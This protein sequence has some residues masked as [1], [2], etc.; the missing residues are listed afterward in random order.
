PSTPSAISELQDAFGS[1]LLARKDATGVNPKTVY[2][3][4][5]RAP[6][7]IVYKW[8]GC[9]DI[10]SFPRELRDRIYYYCLYR[11]DGIV[12]NRNTVRTFPFDHPE[13]MTALFQTSRQVYKEAFQV[14]CRYNTI[15]FTTRNHWSRRTMRG[16]LAGTLRL[17]PSKHADMLQ[18]V[19]KEYSEYFT[20]FASWEDSY[21]EDNPGRVFLQMLR[22]AWTFKSFFPRLRKFTVRWNVWSHYFENNRLVFDKKTEDEKTKIWLNWMRHSIK[23]GN[24]VPMRGLRFEFDNSCWDNPMQEHA[25][26]LNE[27]YE[28]L[29]KETAPFRDEAA[30]L[31]ESGR[32]WLEATS[33]ETRKQRKAKR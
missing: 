8:T 5:L 2:E 28:R 23:Q 18:C 27:A 26:A 12:Y 17:F 19:R 7:P 21:P 4:F 29:L 1:I 14:F 30:E 20:S 11:P 15:T 22:D 25:A 16:G 13:N 24:V 6:E 9:F 31:E 32:K 33:S 10:L 3:P